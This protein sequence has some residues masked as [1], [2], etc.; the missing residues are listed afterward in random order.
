[1]ACEGRFKKVEGGGLPSVTNYDY[2][3]T[4]LY[5]RGTQDR[6]FRFEESS[7]RSTQLFQDQI[8]DGKLVDFTGTSGVFQTRA[9]SDGGPETAQTFSGWVAFGDATF[10]IPETGTTITAEPFS[11]ATFADTFVRSI[12]GAN[13]VGMYGGTNATISSEAGLYQGGLSLAAAQKHQFYVQGKVV[14]GQVTG[15]N[16][17]VWVEGYTGA[18]TES[19]ALAGTNT[20]AVYNTGSESWGTERPTNNVNLKSST[21]EI[22]FDFTTSDFPA[23]TP[24]AYAMF[25]GLSGLASDQ[26]VLYDELHIDQYMRKDAFTDVLLPSGYLLQITPDIGWHDTLSMFGEREAPPNP[27]LATLGPYSLQ[28]GMLD[29]QDGSVTITVSETDFAHATSNN[30]RKYLWRVIG[31]SENGTAGDA[32]FPRRFTYLGKVFDEEFSVTKVWDDPLSITKL[33]TG[34]KSKRMTV[35]VDTAA[36]HPGLEYPT[37]TTWK[38]TIIM[39]S[40]TKQISVQ[41]KDKGGALT[42]EQ[43]IDLRSTAIGLTEKALWNLFDEHGLLLGVERL[44]GESNEDYAGRIKDAFQNPGSHVFKGVVDGGTR[45]LGLDKHVTALTLSFKDRQTPS[46]LT[47]AADVTSASVLLRTS[48]LVHTEVVRIDPVDLTCSLTERIADDPTLAELVD[49]SRVNVD[50]ITIFDEKSERPDFRKIQFEDESLGGEL[51][52]V[53]YDFYREYTFNDYPTLAELVTVL[54]GFTDLLGNDL[55]DVKLHAELSG[56]ESSLGLYIGLDSLGAGATVSF[57]WSPM[58]L[59]RVGDRVYRESFR[60]DD[61][62]LWNTKFYEWITE[63]KSNTNIEWGH[64]IADRAF[65]DAADN[66]LDGFDHLPTLMDPAVAH[67]VHASGNLID[68]E[69]ALA[70]N[71]ADETS[72]KLV[73]T[74]LLAEDFIPGVA[75]VPDLEP[76]VFATVSATPAIADFPDSVVGT[77]GNT[78]VVFFS[79]NIN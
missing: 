77:T 73:S 67:Y 6:S 39:D 31:L 68:A 60:N 49:G 40:P 30:Y 35:L 41:G 69:E 27:H 17:M 46:P 70:R 1:M 24:T 37:D 50:Q 59:K 61:G 71:Y 26:I 28:S 4:N 44:P 79:G 21:T 3:D 62:T 75:H 29:N 2:P 19:I 16:G 20:V 63:L 34:T 9:T 42:S 7:S 76:D 54:R 48:D 45:E 47:L 5:I 72:A 78:P 15:L 43:F 74:L 14:A 38:L 33:I 10:H 56:F 13:S 53:T 36:D 65:W 8:T 58:Y 52:K 32:G 25:V 23:A 57:G 55:I 66:K 51:V 64:V 11:A 12:D 22:K 18:Y